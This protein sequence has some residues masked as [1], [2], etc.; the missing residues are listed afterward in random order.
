METLNGAMVLEELEHEVILVRLLAANGTELTGRQVT[1]TSADP[2]VATVTSFGTVAA[3]GLGETRVIVASEGREATVSV[4]IVARPTLG[5]I[6]DRVSATGNELFTLAPLYGMPARLNAGNVSRHPSPS[7]D[8]RRLVFAVTQ[9]DPLTGAL[10]QDLYVVDRSGLNMR[11]LTSGAGMESA[12][13]WSPDGTRIAFAGHTDGSGAQDIF[14]VNVDGSGIVNLTPNTPLT[15]EADPAWSPDGR[16]IAF[17]SLHTI[18]GSHLY[19]VG[20]DGAGLRQVALGDAGALASNTAH[21][22]WSPDGSRIAFSRRFADGDIDIAIVPATGGVPSRVHVIGEQLEPVWSPDG[23]H[24]AYSGVELLGRS[25]IFTVRV[26]GTAVR[27]R[28]NSV[29]WGGGRNPAWIQLD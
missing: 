1:F 23:V 20:A 29:D 16:S 4:R 17:A 19:T 28:T 11:R 26:D 2:Q 13:V 22:T 5:L 12:P 21:P 8:G 14:V 10:Q 7:P 3:V 9:P 18:G 15:Y 6:Y 25:Q 27:R 24:F